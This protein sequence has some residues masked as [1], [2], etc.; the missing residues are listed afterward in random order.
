MAEIDLYVNEIVSSGTWTE[1]GTTPYL[2][3]QDQP[4]NYTHSASRNANSS[5]FGFADSSDLGTITKVELYIYCQHGGSAN[6]FTPYINANPTSITPPASWDWVSGDVTATV[7]TTWS[8]VNAA[9]C[10][11]D[12]PNTSNDPAVDCAYLKVTYSAGNINVDQNDQNPTVTDSSS[13][14]LNPY[15]VNQS[16]ENP[17][18]TDESLQYLNPYPLINIADENPAIEDYANVSIPLENV[19]IEVW[20]DLSLNDESAKYISPYPLISVYDETELQDESQQYLTIYEINVSDD[21]SLQDDISN[22]LSLYEIYQYNSIT[23]EE[24]AESQISG[25][26]ILNVNV[27]EDIDINDET[28]LYLSIYLIEQYDS[29]SL[30]DYQESQTT[31]AGIQT[32]NVYDDIGIDDYT[33]N[34]LDLY[35]I[36]EGD[37]VNLND[38]LQS[39]ISPL[40]INQ[41]DSILLSDNIIANIS[42]YLVN[43]YESI[44]VI[45]YNLTEKAEASIEINLDENLSLSDYASVAFA[46]YPFLRAFLTIQKSKSIIDIDGSMS[47]LN[48][49]DNR[50][51]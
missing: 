48:V 51:R 15:L 11:F 3:A 43:E 22:Y 31:E 18:I 24:Y 33:L 1:V 7:G 38:T 34:Y 20:D 29:L 39:Y 21:I 44:N 28:S 45:D 49:F 2:S 16:D 6:D 13:Q 14:F 41:A 47:E 4:T 5:V 37:N 19:D 50:G 35:L 10:Y 25:A 27:Y 12:K 40:I 32:I 36:S 46:I 8:G 17:E 42:P 30:E 26:G 9:T 23:V